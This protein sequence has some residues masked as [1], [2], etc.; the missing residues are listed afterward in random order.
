MPV[1][2]H[3]DIDGRSV[4]LTNLDK[5]LYP[6]AQ[7]T[8]AHVIDYY[9]R[10][11][12]CLLPHFKQRPVTLKRFPDGVRGKA[13]Y[14]KD[15][16][17]Y[18]PDWVHTVLVPRQAGGTP[19]R[20]ICIDDLPTLVWC[21]NIAS[22]ELHPFL[23][24]ATQLQTPTSVVFDL[25]PGDGATLVTCAEVAFYLKTFLESMNLQ[26]FP[27]VSG[28]K[29]LQIYIPLNTPVDYTRTR[30][31]AQ[32]V[33][34]SLEIEHPRLIVSEMAKALRRGKVFIDWSQNSDFKTTV[35]VYSL[36]AKSDEPLVS[37]PVTWPELEGMQKRG[38]PN[39]LRFGP[40][41]VLKRV[42]ETGD[43]FAPLLELKQRL[44]KAIPEPERKAS[45][46]KDAKASAARST[47][48][49]DPIAVDLNSLPKAKAKFIEP[50]LLLRTNALPEGNEWLYEVKLDGYRA[51]AIKSGG[52][53]RLRSRNDNDFG[54]K[55]PSIVQALAN[56]PNETV[57]DGEIVALDEQGKPSFNL[58]QNYGSSKAPLLY[59]VFDVLVL[60]G[61]NVMGQ[62]LETRRALLEQHVL[63][64]LADPV[65]YS[66]G[67]E[68]RLPD[69]IKSARAQGLEGLVAKRRNSLY[70]AGQ[71]SG[72]WQKM[73]INQGQE[74]VIGGYT[75]G[76]PTFDALIFGYYDGPRLMYVGRTR[77]GFTP[78]VRQELMKR[79]QSLKTDK[80]PFANLPETKNGRWGQ[81]LT[82]AK[83]KDCRW[84]KPELVGQFE[85]TEWT[86]DDHLRHSRFV[87]LREDKKP[88]DVQRE[89]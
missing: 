81:G 43:L 29:G 2:Q 38:D 3:V 85:F 63:S 74:L 72:A 16:P 28:S 6:G 4:A 84:L 10:V 14:E 33:A 78:R 55:Y 41:A 68:A 54:A 67:L 27:K 42:G 47:R 22:L 32:S 83:M 24:R 19:I 57:L 46:T 58:L 75:L 87:A 64:K 40:D 39:I 49:K 88:R 44:P 66:P 60:D 65:R 21:A 71:R 13:F 25:D 82:A 37:A 61:R 48:V 36:R 9:I 34:Q 69:L 11:A 35:G 52:K 30:S 8:K 17:R 73:R 56:Q 89:Q 62:P 5:V 45:P 53:L 79:F 70:E 31:F 26:C 80:C 1:K 18:T 86:P 77:N 50:M 23:H 51:L 7:F 76:G 20:Y 15:A 59:Y 12:S